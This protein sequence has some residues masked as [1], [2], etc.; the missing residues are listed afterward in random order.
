MTKKKKNTEAKAFNLTFR[1]TDDVLSIHRSNLANWI[2]LIYPKD[3]EIKETAK[4]SSSVHFL[5]FTS[6]LT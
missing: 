5:T 6:N 1:F 4:T 2:P 3:L